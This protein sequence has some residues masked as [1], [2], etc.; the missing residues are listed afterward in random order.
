DLTLTASDLPLFGFGFFIT[1]NDEGF[2]T[3][4]GGSAGNL[5]LLGAIGRFVGPG[6]I[7]NSGSGGEIELTLDLTQIPT[8][9]GFISIQAG[10]TRSFQLWHRDSSS[11][12]TPTSNFTDG[13]RLTFN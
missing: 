3:N 11:G 12:G 13:L 1:S 4:P 2:V 7:Q 6:Q 5:C 8:P 9:T 10:D